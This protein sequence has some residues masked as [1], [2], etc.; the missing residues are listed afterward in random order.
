MKWRISSKLQNKIPHVSPTFSHCVLVCSLL[1]RRRELEFFRGR[2]HIKGTG[3]FLGKRWENPWNAACSDVPQ[4]LL[5]GVPQSHVVYL[6]DVPRTLQPLPTLYITP[7]LLH[8][9][10]WEVQKHTGVVLHK[11]MEYFRGIF[12]H[13]PRKI[14]TN[15][16]Y[17]VVNQFTNL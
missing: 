11:L 16:K 14:G 1:P 3:V 7:D 6:Q 12:W 5:V 8:C 15:A 9:I 13:Q 4:N 10:T 2:Y 17:M